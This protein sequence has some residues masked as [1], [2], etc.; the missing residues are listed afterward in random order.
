MLLQ[1]KSQSVTY[2]ECVFVTLVIQHAMYM[3]LIILSSVPVRLYHVGSY[4]LTKGMTA[5]RKKVIEH[6]MCA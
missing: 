2:S 6:K 1:W 3:R 4:C 5:K